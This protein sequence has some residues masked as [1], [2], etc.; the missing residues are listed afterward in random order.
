[1]NPPEVEAGEQPSDREP[2]LSAG[3]LGMRT[4][5]H[6]F[7]QHQGSTNDCGPFCVAIAV[8]ALREEAIL[9]GHAVARWMERVRRSAGR[10]PLPV[11]DKVPGWATLPW[12]IGDELRRHGLRARWRLFGTREHL[13]HNLAAD[14]VTA[15]AVGEPL[16]FVKG[17]WRG[18]GHLK[19]LYAWDPQ[20]GWAFVDPGVRPWPGDPWAARGIGWQREE[21]FVRQ[22]MW[23]LRFTMEVL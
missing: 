7:H 13:L 21:E 9:D 19:L 17:R 22:W 14:R 1:M 16:R 6:R 5:L 8:N 23:M 4:P 12:G 10:L 18:W 3:A 11:L 2:A 15:V 20:W